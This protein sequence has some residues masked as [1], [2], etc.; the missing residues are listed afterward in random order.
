MKIPD[1]GLK[2]FG[3]I[4]QT[5]L[6]YYLVMVKVPREINKTCKLKTLHIVC[7]WLIFVWIKWFKS[8]RADTIETQFCDKLQ[9]D[10]IYSF[11]II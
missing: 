7:C 4:E 1:Y 5:R 6:R 10:L 3:V 11:I 2:G 9:R 8:Y